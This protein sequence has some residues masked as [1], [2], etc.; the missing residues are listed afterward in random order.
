MSEP[1]IAQL[2]AKINELIQR[3]E[4]LNQQHQKLQAKEQAWLTE[5]ARLLEKN[6]IAKARI[7]AIIER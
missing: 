7:E 3:H 2:D 6:E 1:I 5:R 4:R